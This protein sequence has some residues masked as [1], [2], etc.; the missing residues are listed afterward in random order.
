M[1]TRGRNS[2]GFK[3]HGHWVLSADHEMA[4]PTLCAEFAG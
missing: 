1:R 2:V 4:T 3:P